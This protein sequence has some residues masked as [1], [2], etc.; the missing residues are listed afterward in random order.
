MDTRLSKKYGP[1]FIISFCAAL[2]LF[3]IVSSVVSHFAYR[4]YKGIAEDLAGGSVDFKDGNILHYGIIAKRE[5][6]AI[7]EKEEDEKLRKEMEERQNAEDE[8]NLLNNNN[9]D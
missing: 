2:I 7:E 5:D 1:T 8:E 6:D 9:R 3:Y 4:E